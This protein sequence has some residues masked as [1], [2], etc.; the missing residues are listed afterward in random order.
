MQTSHRHTLPFWVVG[1][2]D[3]CDG[4]P[5]KLRMSGAIPDLDPS[6]LLSL[7]QGFQPK[8]AIV[9]GRASRLVVG[10]GGNS[11]DDIGRR[12]RDTRPNHFN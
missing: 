8:V 10:V 4:P 2:F 1:P 12:N 6:V 11:D 9:Q 7:F 3:L 5:K